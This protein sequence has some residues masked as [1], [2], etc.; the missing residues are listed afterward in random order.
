MEKKKIV[1]FH[2]YNDFSGSPKVLRQ[3]VRGFLEQ[4]HEVDLVTSR[5]GV[6]DNA[7][8]TTHNS[9]LRIK[10]VTKL[11]IVNYQL[12]IRMWWLP[13]TTTARVSLSSRELS[14]RYKK[15]AKNSRLQGPA[16]R[17]HYP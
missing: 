15:H 13:Q 9:Q 16:E 8:F 6:L 11:S 4:G 17:C 5:G 3:V 12:P 7:Q 14:R 1:C 10:S 2:L